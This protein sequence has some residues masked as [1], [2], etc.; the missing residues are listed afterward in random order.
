MSRVWLTVSE[1]QTIFEDIAN[2]RIEGLV[3]D[4]VVV[5]QVC[6]R[7]IDIVEGCNVSCVTEL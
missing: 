7:L 6:Q 3:R 2:H 1:D 4:F 5:P